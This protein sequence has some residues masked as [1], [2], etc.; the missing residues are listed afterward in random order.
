MQLEDALA[1]HPAVHP[2][3]M[4]SHNL[5]GDVAQGKVS[6][7]EFAPHPRNNTVV[8]IDELPPPALCDAIEDQCVCLLNVLDV[9]R[10]MRRGIVTQADDPAPEISA[11]FGLLEGEIHRV[12]AGLKE[13][14]LRAQM[15][16]IVASYPDT[17]D[18]GLR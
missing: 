13:I 11:A 4:S 5:A 18:A 1:P 14:A 16:G 3:A 2:K 15:R 12:V 9:V 8:S 10:C 17:S 6:A 7:Y